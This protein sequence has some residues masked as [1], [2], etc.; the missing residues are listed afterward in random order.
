MPNR[1]IATDGEYIALELIDVIAPIIDT[2]VAVQGMKK[3]INVLEA[4]DA[5]TRASGEDILY[6]ADG[7]VFV[8][9]SNNPNYL[10][11]HSYNGD[12]SC[13][14]GGEPFITE[15]PDESQPGAIPFYAD[16]LYVYGEEVAAVNVEESTCILNSFGTTLAIARQERREQQD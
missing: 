1:K 5:K 11:R 4:A 15:L 7:S 16:F 9:R 14:T 8:L 12:G 6:P 13:W 2:R 10:K 3:A